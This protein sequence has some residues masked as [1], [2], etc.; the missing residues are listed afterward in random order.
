MAGC[1]FEGAQRLESELVSEQAGSLSF[2]LENDSSSSASF[3]LELAAEVHTRVVKPDQRVPLRVPIAAGR[4]RLALQVKG[5]DTGLYLW[6]AP[7]LRPSG[8][9][10]PGP[11]VLVSLDTTRRDVLSPYGGDESATP[12][13]RAF[14]DHATVYDAAQASSPWTLPSHAS[15]FT[16]LYPSRHGAGVTDDHLARRH[17]TVAELLRRR[18]YLPAGFA[19]GELCSSRWGLAQGFSIYRNPEGF[20]T[21]GDRLTDQVLAFLERHH[22]DPFFLFVNY[23]DPHALYEAPAEFQDAFGVPE[24][25]TRLRSRPIWKDFAKG[26]VN[27]WRRIISGEAEV[28]AP[29]LEFLGAA[30]LAEVAF[31]DHEIG[32]LL[33][34]LR[35]Y[36]L[37]DE[38]LIVLVSDHGELLGEGGFFSHC[39][40]LVPELIEVPLLIKFPGQ[41]E[42][43][44]VAELVSHVDLYPTLLA[45]DDLP[46]HDGLRLGLESSDHLRARGLVLMEE[47]LSR[48]HPLFENMKIANHLF[49]IQRPTT[50]EIVWEGGIECS[51]LTGDRWRDSPCGEGW[52]ERLTQL[53]ALLRLPEDRDPDGDHGE[54]SED[55]RRRLEALGYLR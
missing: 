19:G 20:E 25:R 49:G 55:E 45:T 51:V 44:R 43:R 4:H 37:Y 5:E 50:R 34:A 35:E 7:Y 30:Y 23:F 47:H 29:V 9:D 24:L 12:N 33:A 13:I 17:L 41:R 16:G 2:V 52:R 38:A 14:A 22:A 42:A 54:L 3:T 32:R 10:L 18:G 39:C 48:I 31:M 40:R 26:D 28:V 46:D 15:I 11:V 21:R 36:G 27:A 6:G 1:L 53:E 8:S